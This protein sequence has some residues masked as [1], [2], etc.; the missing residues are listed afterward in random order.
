MSRKS[1]KLL[2]L[3]RTYTAEKLPWFAPALFACRIRLTEQVPV[4][5][6]S[7]KMDIFFN[8]EAVLEIAEESIPKPQVLAELGFLWIH[9]I[10]HVLR[11]HGERGREKNADA[12]LWN[13]ACDLEINDGSWSGFS[14]PEKFRPY[15]PDDFKLPCEQIAEFYY[16]KLLKQA[17]SEEGSF[18]ACDFDDE[19]SGVH[20][21]MRP[22]EVS[23]DEE[24]KQLD[25]LKLDHI[26]SEVARK[27]REEFSRDNEEQ[28]Q[29]SSSGWERWVEEQ[30]KPK[31]DWRKAI[32]QRLRTVITQGVGSRID[33]SFGRMNRRQAVYDPLIIPSLAGSLEVMISCV[34]DTSGSIGQ[35]ELSQVLGE[36][37]GM[38]Q[39]FRFP[40][41]IIPCDVRSY[42]AIE[43]KT[44]SDLFQIDRLPGGGG[45]NMIKGIEAALEQKPL[46]NVVVVL[47]DGF[48]PFPPKP[49]SVPVI[50]GLLPTPYGRKKNNFRKPPIP[51]WPESSVVEI[52]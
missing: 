50:W 49:Y 3:A 6:I 2:R 28:R 1:E 15:Y 10:L 24:E 52:Q 8:A 14:P 32:K 51:P 38:L 13:L 27:W 9:E 4:A 41:T 11:R 23:L 36:I 29:G 42:E 35:E 44:L 30:L 34:V 19:G 26:R 46:P 16:Q 25:S 40:V 7:E 48:T 12:R 33:Y 37:M 17:E 45:T 18:E 5:A 47:T 22:W 39:T 20:G 43:V 21:Q 31:I